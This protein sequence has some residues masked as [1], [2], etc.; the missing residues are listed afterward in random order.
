MI[1][2]Y[3]CYNEF[4]GLKN[5]KRSKKIEMIRKARSHLF[6]KWRN[7]AAHLYTLLA[8]IS[9]SM[10]TSHNTQLSAHWTHRGELNLMHK[11][12]FSW[13]KYHLTFCQC[14]L[15]SPSLSLSMT[16]AELLHVLCLQQE[17]AWSTHKPLPP[18]I[19]IMHASGGE[20]RPHKAWT[21]WVIYTVNYAVFTLFTG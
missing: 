17:L 19:T 3:I 8:N 11:H 20:S 15:P 9:Y 10:Q 12:I 5:D 7:W 21:V 13:F 1:S 18:A 6:S 16:D 14:H 4:W 2:I